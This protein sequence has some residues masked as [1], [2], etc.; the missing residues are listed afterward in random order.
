M[1]RKKS[2]GKEKIGEEK[3]GWRERAI[4]GGCG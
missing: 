1:K 4:D 2:K 3:M